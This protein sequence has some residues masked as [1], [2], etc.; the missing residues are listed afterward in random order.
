MKQKRKRG[1]GSLRYNLCALTISLTDHQPAA[2]LPP[3][4]QHTWH[5]WQHTWH[6]W[7]HTS[8][9]TASMLVCIN[10]VFK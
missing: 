1:K 4:R 6:T 8:Q 2:F 3:V 9:I 5:T 10:W 7:Q